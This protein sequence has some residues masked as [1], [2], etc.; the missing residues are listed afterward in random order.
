MNSS[1]LQSKPKAISAL[2]LAGG[3]SQ[4]FDSNDKGLIDFMDKPMVQHVLER[5]APQVASVSISCNRH[6]EQ[7]Q[8]IQQNYYKGVHQ[9]AHL[10]PKP[11]ASSTFAAACI[12]DKRHIE[13]QGPLAG[14]YTYLE[15]CTSELIFICSCDMP[16]LPS[17][18]VQQLLTPL[19][20]DNA[21]ASY[22][23]DE[24]GHHHLAVLVKPPAARIA[25]QQLMDESKNES[26]QLN[27]KTKQHSIKNWLNRLKSQ[28][29][30]IDSHAIGFTDINSA[31]ELAA[32]EDKKEA[33]KPDFD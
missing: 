18:I 7:Y 31:A 5:V 14:I 4:R 16:M 26:H 27:L 15:N 33:Q 9:Q 28:Q 13:L 23:I 19:N 30:I 20:N 11:Q 21:D 25:L 3:Q 17:D 2:I 10:N 1:T 8:A 6:I 22:P 12:E 24:N 29:M 32:I